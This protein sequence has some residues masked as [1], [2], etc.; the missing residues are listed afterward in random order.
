MGIGGGYV[1][2]AQNDGNQRDGLGPL[3]DEKNKAKEITGDE[4]SIARREACG[5]CL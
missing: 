2:S 1:G 3:R 4:G 5:M